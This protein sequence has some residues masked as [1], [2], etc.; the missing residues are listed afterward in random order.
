MVSAFPGELKHNT[1]Q[2]IIWAQ[3]R[4]VDAIGLIG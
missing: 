3:P 4:S 1:D 2:A